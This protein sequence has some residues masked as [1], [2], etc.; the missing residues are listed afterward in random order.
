MTA[1][2]IDEDTTVRDT[3]EEKRKIAAGSKDEDK[4]LNFQTT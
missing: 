3:E 4:E 2:G 1:R